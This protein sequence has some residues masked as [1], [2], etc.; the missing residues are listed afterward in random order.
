MKL[1]LGTFLITILT[2]IALPYLIASDYGRRA[3][4]SSLAELIQFPVQLE[5]APTLSW[6]KE[7][8]ATLDKL[9]IGTPEKVVVALKHARLE[10]NLLSI[11]RFKPHLSLARVDGLMFNQANLPNTTQVAGSIQ[12]LNSET[13][14]NP[15]SETSSESFAES[16][17]ESKGPPS[18]FIPAIDKLTVR[19]S[20]FLIGRTH[21]KQRK[22]TI[23]ALNLDAFQPG[24]PA[25]ITGE[26]TLDGEPIQLKLNLGPLASLFTENAIAFGS[27]AAHQ[28][29]DLTLDAEYSRDTGITF[30]TELEA[31]QSSA[32]S[33]L[34][35]VKLPKWK[36]I[37]L[38]SE[39]SLKNQVITFANLILE[40][41]ND[42]LSGSG[43]VDLRTPGRSGLEIKASVREAAVGAKGFIFDD[44]RLE[45]E[46]TSAGKN[47]G[48]LSTFAFAELP[49]FRNYNVSG[50]LT[51][52]TADGEWLRF[53]DLQLTLNKSILTGK[54]DLRPKPLE[55]NADLTSDYFSLIDLQTKDEAETSD[56]EKALE[57]E[58]PL[59]IEFLNELDGEI[60][61][62]VSKLHLF[63]HHTIEE[64]GI[65]AKLKD[66]V[67]KASE[68]RANA[69]GGR[70]LGSSEIGK[71]RIHVDLS[72]SR[73]EASPLALIADGEPFF[74]GE[75][76]FG[77]ELESKGTT[78]SQ[79]L[80]NMNG[81]ASVTSEHALLNSGTLRAASSGLFEILSPIIGDVNEAKVECIHYAYDIKDGIAK[82]KDQ[83][84]KLG[85]VFI[86]AEGD[87]NLPENKIRYNMHVNSKKPA[88]ASLI[89][90]FRAFGSIDSPFFTPSVSGSVASVADTV[91]GVTQTATGVL[92]SAKRF[93]MGE[94]LENHKGLAACKQA[95]KIEKSLL[96]SQIG[97]LLE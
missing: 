16:A 27:T 34:L 13:A 51:G 36:N 82:A 57:A 18:F 53:T 77:I 69:I 14:F 11:L 9:Q 86:F 35:R 58:K 60:K 76:D 46:V 30:T 72:G 85:E 20:T 55:I 25:S 24:N 74:R 37:K 59:S 95:I 54:L 88:L 23:Q 29:L 50:E 28:E 21:A 7:I 89:P 40:A 75:F 31:Q 39:F 94:D 90:P 2:L 66:G 78:L 15:I 63:E 8:V 41:N 42:L 73:F 45:L 44:D 70:L 3:V 61:L 10:L 52:S 1:T 84:I 80:E 22:L 62:D 47:L 79:M 93:L 68:I 49:D 96:S 67:L 83:V 97:D 26:L 38:A 91:E 33:R 56:S 19:D 81:T 6:G 65:H 64:V 5:E 87:L 12:A 71:E 92:S 4:E 32:L 48:E 43:K 17:S